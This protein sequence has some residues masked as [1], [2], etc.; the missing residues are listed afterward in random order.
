MEPLGQERTVTRSSTIEVH[1]RA[2]RLNLSDVVA[3]LKEH[4]GLAALSILT[5]DSDAKTIRGWAEGVQPRNGVHERRLR[6]AY[7]IF[8]EIQ[9][10]EAPPT[11]RAWFLG[12]NP[13]LDDQ[14]P[15]EA[16]ANGQEREVL[17]A[18]R[19]FIAGG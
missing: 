3:Y 13:Q 19:S 9:Q 14:A 16:L 6:S 15:I 17:S 1:R 11:V 7:Q 18:A 12:M 8:Q 2:V 10:V 5:D 4:L